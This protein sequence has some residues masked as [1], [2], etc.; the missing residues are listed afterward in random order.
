MGLGIP[1]YTPHWIAHP[2]A[3]ESICHIGRIVSSNRN[4]YNGLTVGLPNGLH[5]T[6]A[7]MMLVSVWLVKRNERI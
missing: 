4:R 2:E 6:G 3:A 5:R 7:G 1:R